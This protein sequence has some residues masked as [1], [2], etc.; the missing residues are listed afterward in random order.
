MPRPP[1]EIRNLDDEERRRA[2]IHRKLRWEERF[3]KAL[4]LLGAIGAIAL[5]IYLAM[6]F[7]YSS[8]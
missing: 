8:W 6:L 3:R 1:S 5:I 7:G 2:R 4:W